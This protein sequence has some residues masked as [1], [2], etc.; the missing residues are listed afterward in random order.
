MAMTFEFNIRPFGYHNDPIQ[1]GRIRVH[2]V[3]SHHEYAVDYKTNDG[4]KTISGSVL[5]RQPDGTKRSGHRN[6]LHLLADIMDDIDL[7]ALGE[8]Y[9]NV[10]AEVEL[11]HPFIKDTGIA[12][13]PEF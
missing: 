6:F 8:D 2:S 3:D 5:K 12:D 13:Y 10:L 4:W 11:A 7:D 1:F 9:V